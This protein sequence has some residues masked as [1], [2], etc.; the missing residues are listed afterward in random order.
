MALADISL[1]RQFRTGNQSQQ[2]PRANEPRIRVLG[3]SFGAV[4]RFA[5]EFRQEFKNKAGA[6]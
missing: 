5:P 6:L 1:I 2:H 3:K 4:M